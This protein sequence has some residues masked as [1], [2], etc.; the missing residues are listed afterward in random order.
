M[1]GP[2]AANLQKGPATFTMGTDSYFTMGASTFGMEGTINWL[3]IDD[4]WA[5]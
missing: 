1:A 3:T 4:H 2:T 5:R